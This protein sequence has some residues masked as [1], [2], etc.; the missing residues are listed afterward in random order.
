M[1]KASRRKPWFR[2]WANVGMK[3]AAAAGVT[4][5]QGAR[6]TTLENPVNMLRIDWR[7]ALGGLLLAALGPFFVRVAQ[8]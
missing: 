7:D 6:T 2:K 8:G 4:L 5:R 3:A 1:A